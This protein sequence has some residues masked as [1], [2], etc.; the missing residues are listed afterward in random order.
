MDRQVLSVAA[1]AL[2]AVAAAMAVGAWLTP[3]PP[4]AMPE[5]PPAS[6]P[7]QSAAPSR[8]E[9]EQR[10]RAL[11]ER[12]EQN[13]D[14]LAGWKMLGRSYAAQG[15]YMEAVG[16]YSRA[17][18]IDPRDPEVAGALKQLETIARERGRHDETVK[19]R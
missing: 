11:E 7:Q 1:A 2:V 14:D 3:A 4:P 19:M 6:P 8:A 9:V 5:V 12:M 17:A 13:P 10:I 15:R 16:V 18:Q